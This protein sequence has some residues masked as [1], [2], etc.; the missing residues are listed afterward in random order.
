MNN[1]SPWRCFT[2]WRLRSVGALGLVACLVACGGGGEEPE[3]AQSLPSAAPASPSSE[4]PGAAPPPI[5]PAPIPPSAASQPAILVIESGTNPSISLSADGLTVTSFGGTINPKCA[6]HEGIYANPVFAQYQS[7]VCRKRGVRANAGV[8][9]GEF[10]YFEGT[11]LVSPQNF[12]FGITRRDDNIDPLCCY[13]GGVFGV[14]LPHALTTPSMS[15]NMVNLGVFVNLL[16]ADSGDVITSPLV[17][18]YGFAIDYSQANPMVYVVQKTAGGAMKVRGYQTSGFNGVEAVP[19][20]YGD[21]ALNGS[22]VASVNFG[23]QPFYFNEA[24]LRAELLI[25]M[26]TAH[27]LSPTEAAAKLKLLSL[28]V[29]TP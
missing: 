8:R 15:F 4:P 11:R 17:Q 19:M 21:F 26:T 3:L 18:H 25:R 13:V 24:T 10:R 28:G 16:A 14:D 20:M 29:V 9:Q 7:S 1:L 12:A 2:S 22:P 23:Q 6:A 5:S 27:D